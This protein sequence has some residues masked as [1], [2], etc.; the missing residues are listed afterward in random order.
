MNH[1]SVKAFMQAQNTSKKNGWRRR[2]WSR[3]WW[4]RRVKSH[5]CIRHFK[6]H[7]SW[8][9]SS[10]S[11]RVSDHVRKLSLVISGSKTFEMVIIKALT[12]RGVDLVRRWKN[13]LD[14]FR[15]PSSAC[16]N[17]QSSSEKRPNK[18]LALWAGFIVADVGHS[19]A[20]VAK[21]NRTGV[22]SYFDWFL[23]IVVKEEHKS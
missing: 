6:L 20:V 18:T 19:D 16:D 22:Q 15:W 14:S 1:I 2:M 8:L 3:S 10:Q 11:R 21:D 23:P 17:P 9:V 13:L 5:K 4:G 7:F 12:H